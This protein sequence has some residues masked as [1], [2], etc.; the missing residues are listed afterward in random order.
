MVEHL[1]KE[2]ADVNG[3]GGCEED[4][5]IELLVGESLFDEALAIVEGAGDFESGD[6]L[7][8]SGELFLL[9]FA[10]AFR[11]IKNHDADSGH[12]KKTVGNGAAGVTGSG[13]KDGEL[14]RFAA[15]EIAHEAGQKT[16]TKV[17]ER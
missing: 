14:A 7:A 15:D 2:A 8:E 5:L 11:R 1:R 16:R 17:L 6:V 3:V 4:A 10:D 9:G 13:D 12:A